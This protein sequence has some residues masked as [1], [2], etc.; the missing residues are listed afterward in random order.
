[1]T[2]R[3]L[4]SA[5]SAKTA[6]DRLITEREILFQLVSTAAAFVVLFSSDVGSQANTEN[7]IYY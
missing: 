7:S 5:F 1:M 3:G 2:E 4:I 6:I